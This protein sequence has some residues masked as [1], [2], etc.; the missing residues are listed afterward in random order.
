MTVS[1]TSHNQEIV[2]SGVLLR[3][4]LLMI[5]LYVSLIAWMLTGLILLVLPRSF[6]VALAR[7]WSRYF[8]WL[9][10]VVGGI[11]VEFRGLNNI[12]KGPLLI[13]AKHQSIWE[14]FALLS[15]FEDPC[16]ILKR[17]LAFIP[18]FGWFLAKMR[19]VPIDRKGGARTLLKLVKAAHHE[20]GSGEGRQ[21]LLFPEGTRR[22]PGAPPEYR[23]GIAQ[24]YSGLNV[25]C[26]PIALNSGVYWPR[27][28]LKLRQGTIIVDIMPVIEPGLDRQTFFA[29]MQEKIEE[30]SDR[31]LAEAR[32]DLGLPFN[33]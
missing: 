32:H 31:L 19:N 30:S 13:A 9:C 4:L 29:L 20:I 28:S 6:V 15:L 11:S 16:F 7:A 22:A 25:P 23:F 27:R 3:S 5:A 26:L 8:L 17:E 24:I 21:I 10:R 18:L 12:P 1:T 2:Q 33:A 14:T